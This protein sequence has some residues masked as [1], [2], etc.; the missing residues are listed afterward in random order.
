MYLEIDFRSA[1]ALPMIDSAD[2]LSLPK[3]YAIVRLSVYG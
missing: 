3:A 2:S 1:E